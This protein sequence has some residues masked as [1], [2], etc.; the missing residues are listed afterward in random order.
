MSKLSRRNDDCFLRVHIFNG[1]RPYLAARTFDELENEVPEIK[2][3]PTRSEGEITTGKRRS[4]RIHISMPVLV[5]G[6]HGGTAFEE[7]TNTVTVSAYGC[8]L[9]IATRLA[10]GQQI[11]LVNPQ[12][13]EEVTCAV[14]YVTQKD[15]KSAE[16]GIEFAEPST[17]FWRINFPPENADPDERKRPVAPR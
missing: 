13:K 17:R 16:V 4:Q 9:Y 3:S 12:T 10:R 1:G 5:K 2:T 8:M 7:L 11:S 6:V 14:S 15:S